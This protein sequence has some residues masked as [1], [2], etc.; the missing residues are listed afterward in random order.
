MHPKFGC[1]L[2]PSEAKSHLE[3][4]SF[5]EEGSPRFNTSPE[6]MQQLEKGASGSITEQG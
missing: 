2:K 6:E 4:Q 5:M 3:E 1:K